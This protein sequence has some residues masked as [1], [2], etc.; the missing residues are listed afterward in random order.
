[1][2][3]VV[4]GRPGGAA[5]GRHGGAAVVRLDHPQR[6]VGSDPEVVVVA[7]R[8]ADRR[9]APAAV[10]RAVEL[11]VGDVDGLLVPGVGD[12]PGVVPGALAEVALAARLLP[13]LAAVLRAEDA[14]VLGLDQG[15]EVLGIGGG[16]RDAD[17]PERPLGHARLARQLVPGV[18]AVGRLPEG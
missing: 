1:G 11:D 8:G 14:T 13:G 6:V 9:P 7:V 15:V 2:R 10:L 3:L 12:D 18:A 5:V 16:N 17:D 4:L